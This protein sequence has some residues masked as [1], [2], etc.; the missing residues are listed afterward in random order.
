M[1]EYPIYGNANLDFSTLKYGKGPWQDP[2]PWRYLQVTL[3]GKN[4]ILLYSKDLLRSICALSTFSYL[5]LD[6]PPFQI[7]KNPFYVYHTFR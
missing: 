1:S 2:G 5:D 3:L 4:L 6:T 7:F